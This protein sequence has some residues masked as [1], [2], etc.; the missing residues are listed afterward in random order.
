MLTKD[1]IKAAIKIGSD[2]GNTKDVTIMSDMLSHWQR[3][4]S[5]TPRQKD[6]VTKLIARNSLAKAKE[7][8]EWTSEW[9]ADKTLQ[10]KAGVIAEYYL[11]SNDYFRGVALEVRNWLKAERATDLENT[12]RVPRKSSVLRMI[13]NAYAEKVWQSYISKPLWSVG[14]LVQCRSTAA[15]R[16]KVT[17]GIYWR[18]ENEKVYTIIQVNSRPIDKA[19][20]Y[21]EKQGGARYYR[22]LMLGSTQIVDV[23]EQ[24]LKK[25]PK[26]LLN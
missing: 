7:I 20:G 3:R 12:F 18:L 16:Y 9:V 14:Q 5:L 1:D 26:K 22:L 13:E 21:K 23:L 17:D 11:A 15:G 4:G 10:E 25:V 19:L 24:D 6:F 2:L 8:E